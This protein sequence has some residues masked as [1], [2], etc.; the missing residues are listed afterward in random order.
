MSFNKYTVSGI[1]QVRRPLQCLLLGGVSML[2]IGLA[3]PAQ[4]QTDTSSAVTNAVSQENQTVETVV[5][6]GR[7][8]ALQSAQEI[9]ANS[10]QIVDAVVADQAGKLPDNSVTEVL[11]RVPGVT[12]GR[13]AAVGNP[14]VFSIEGSG[15]AVRGLTQVASTLNG[16]SAFSANG[17]RSLAWE[18]IPPEL[19][20][21]VSVYKSST[22]DQIEGGIGGSIDLRTHMPFDYDGFAVNG[23]VG[24]NYG[25]F[26]G[27]IRPAGSALISDRW[28]TRLGEFGLLL[29]ASY[30]DISSRFDTFQVEPFFQETLHSNPDGSP[31]AAGV[32]VFMPG[33]FDWRTGPV[34]RKRAGFYEAMQWRPTE[35]LTIY[36]T[37][38]SSYYFQTSTNEAIYYANGNSETVPVGATYT[39]S[40]S[41]LVTSA[42]HLIYTNHD[43][44]YNTPQEACPA[45]L[46]TCTQSFNDIGAGKS[47]N[48]TTDIATG[49]QFEATDHLYL[50]GALQYTHSTA[51]S[52][53]LDIFTLGIVSDISYQTHGGNLPTVTMFD[54]KLEADPSRAVFDA[55][56][57]NEG[58]HWGSQLAENLDAK[59]DFGP[60]SFIRSIKAGVRYTDLKDTD[61]GGAGGKYN[62]HSLTPGWAACCGETFNYL[63]DASPGDT[64]LV[65]FD[66]FFRGKGA[67]SSVILPSLALVQSNDP[68]AISAKYGF[69]P[70]AALTWLDERPNPNAFNLTPTDISR[71]ATRTEAAYLMADFG[72]DDV[73]GMVM[74]GNIGV[75]VVNNA[76]QSA[77]YLT[78]QAT[79]WIIGGSPYVIDASA[80]ATGGGYHYTKVLPSLNIQFLPQDNIHVRFA[81]SQSMA[82]PSFSQLAASGSGIGFNGCPGTT[83]GVGSVVVD[84]TGACY[85]GTSTLPLSGSVNG[86]P[87]LRPQ[88]SD[89]L[90]ISAEW[91]G[92]NQAAAHV[93]LFLK[94]IHNYMAY[95]T[96]NGLTQ[97]PLPDGTLS[98]PLPLQTNGWYNQ[99]G[100]ATIRGVEMGGTKYFDFLP[101]PFD[102]T[103]VDANFTYIDSRSPG[104]QSCQLFP[105]AT[106]SALCGA[107]EP[108][109]GLPVE[110]LSRYNYNLTLLYDKGAWSGRL[111]YNW[112]SKY[113]LVSSGANGTQTL[114]VFSAPYGQLDGGVEYKI[115][116]HFRVSADG[117][118]LTHTLAY[119]LQGF[120]SPTYGNL[121][122]ERNFFVSDTRYTVSVKFNY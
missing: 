79:T 68:K 11:Q 20:A 64:Q 104:S 120:T 71:S 46:G 76:N 14:D 113:M 75:R 84:P 88:V 99:A 95:G 112:R 98:V 89:N 73:F 56:M 110:Q 119:T 48:R 33:G 92:E 82:N 12:I 107:N 62:W 51:G 25:D 91:Y 65:T 49:F 32:N 53:G 5:V 61:N 24:A 26:K 42:S 93:G 77:G 101:A 117:Q 85:K 55:E 30:A 4:A 39:L 27:Q 74:N 102:G 81:A 9:K 108:I 52:K 87:F 17:G 23:S 47:N 78:R 90:D 29:D 28:Q 116:D 3:L 37:F 15:V 118:N 103:G 34:D 70:T 97:V 100:V 44:F 18:D 60:G 111:A 22:A 6:T 54:P 83:G 50:S 63:S 86:D 114:P 109:T 7:R 105:G 8:A 106:T 16:R 115:D 80:V 58:Y 40:P 69:A 2:S 21:A 41:H 121:Q 66:N 57:D 45:A 38:F 13:F 31:N 94:S 1:R 96:F 10:D 43:G 72:M 59:Y 122:T 19:M 35:R 67:P 36:Q